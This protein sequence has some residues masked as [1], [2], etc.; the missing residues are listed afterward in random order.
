MS[1]IN[2]Y[3][4]GAIRGGR[5]DSAIYVE[6][7]QILR[8]YGNVLAEHVAD[9]E[10]SALGELTEDKA[11]HDRDVSWLRQS[12]YLVAEVT[13]PSLGVGYELGKA[14]E[15]AKPTLCLYRPSK[16]RHLSAMVAGCDA[17]VVRE[18]E[19]V[20]ELKGILDEF[21]ERNPLRPR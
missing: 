13:I 8:Q 14:T 5:E 16:V 15:W 4:A 3:F 1:T 18:Y 19:T 2:I 9:T 6:I 21:F 11:I 10:L 17:L 20:A 12:D 7:V